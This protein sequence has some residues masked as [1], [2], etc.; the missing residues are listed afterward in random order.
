MPLPFVQNWDTDHVD[1]KAGVV[2][3]IFVDQSENE[4]GVDSGIVGGKRGRDRG[5]GN[6]DSQHCYVV[7][8]TSLFY[9]PE[10]LLPCATPIFPWLSLSHSDIAD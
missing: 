2:V 3:A 7:D 8:T 5:I 6:T 9:S 10:L 4:V 1:K